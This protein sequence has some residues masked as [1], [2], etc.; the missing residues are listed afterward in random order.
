MFTLVARVA[1]QRVGDSN[2]YLANRAWTHTTEGQPVD[3]DLVQPM[4]KQHKELTE[5]FP[6]RVHVNSANHPDF[7]K[8]WVS[9]F[10][11]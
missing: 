2:T 7:K 1:E 8:L 9:K 10:G 4:L 5:A 3:K 6:R 11:M